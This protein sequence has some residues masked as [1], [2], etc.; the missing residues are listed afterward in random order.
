MQ[1]VYLSPRA[2]FVENSL[3]SGALALILFLFLLDRLVVDLSAA[4]LNGAV[5]ALVLALLEIHT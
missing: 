3:L 5:A 1:S 4:Q 2:K